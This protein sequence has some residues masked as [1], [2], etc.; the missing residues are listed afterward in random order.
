MGVDSERQVFGSS[1]H[2]HSKHAFGNQLPCPVSHDA[3]PKNTLSFRVDDE[4]GH[5]VRTIE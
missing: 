1:T 4:L 2:L 3:D 5:A